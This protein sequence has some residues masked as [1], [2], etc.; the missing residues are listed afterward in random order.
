MLGGKKLNEL[1][2]KDIQKI[3]DQ[4]LQRAMNENSHLS[5]QMNAA[6][7]EDGNLNEN[8]SRL[9]GNIGLNGGYQKANGSNFGEA[10]EAR[11]D[12]QNSKIKVQDGIK[13]LGRDNTR[14]SGAEDDFIFEEQRIQGGDQ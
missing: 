2:K 13:G 10:I 12:G 4:I 5:S 6:I 14:G 11:R 9:Q 8:N 3:S 1:S 7:S